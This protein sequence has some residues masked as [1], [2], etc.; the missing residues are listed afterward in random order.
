MMSKTCNY[1]Q[2][3]IWLCAI[4]CNFFA[5]FQ[6]PIC[7]RLVGILRPG[8]SLGG[9]GK[10]SHIQQLRATVWTMLESVGS[11]TR[12]HWNA[13]SQRLSDSESTVKHHHW[14]MMERSRFPRLTGMMSHSKIVRRIETSSE[15]PH[16]LATRR[17]RNSVLNSA[18]SSVRNDAMETSDI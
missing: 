16:R 14:V 11:S 17:I 1:L 18:N 10:S 5:T 6:L 12:S 3:F 7:C 9:P 2:L 4:K 8:R 15:Q 13:A